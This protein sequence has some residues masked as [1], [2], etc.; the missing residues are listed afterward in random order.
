MFKKIDLEKTV[1]ID[2]ETVPEF[3]SYDAMDAAWQYHWTDKWRK[4]RA[5][6]YR[7]VFDKEPPAAADTDLT[8]EAHGAYKE[9][10]LYAEFGKICCVTVGVFKEYTTAGGGR[11]LQVNSFY[12]PD[13][14]QILTMLCKGLSG[15]TERHRNG[16]NDRYCWNLAGHNVRE[17]DV[18][19]LCRR[20]LVNGIDLPELLDCAGLKP[21]EVPHVVDTMELWK[22]G[23]YK[24]YTPLNL[25]A[26]RFGV[27]SPKGEMDGSGVYEAYLQGNF[28]SIGKYCGL[29]VLT[30][31]QLVLRWRNEEL[32]QEDEIEMKMHFLPVPVL[33]SA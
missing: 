18:P 32:L 29:D 20:M 17:F 23:D 33:A 14:E 5:Q 10:G 30:V 24:A 3:A 8:A 13:E 31:A 16:R 12:G 9:A 7:M 25:L 15:K 19:Y 22:F 2:I 11:H 28:D 27:P 26:Q 4:V 1:F 6:R 21:W